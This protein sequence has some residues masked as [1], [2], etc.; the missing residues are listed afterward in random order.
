MKKLLICVAAAFLMLGGCEAKP[1][2]DGNIE[3]GTRVI[4]I[5]SGFS[6]VHAYRGETVTL[7]FTGSGSVTLSVPDYEVEQSGN[8]AVSVTFKAVKT[9][10]YGIAVTTDNGTETGTLIIEELADTNVYK[11]V[12]AQAFEEAMTGQFLLLDVRTK[13]EYE[14]G[15]IDGAVLI[16]H[17]ELADRLDEIKGYDKVLVYCASGNRSVAASQI[18]INAGFEEVYNLAYGYADWQD[19]KQG[20]N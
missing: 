5:G 2:A 16:P 11:S 12:D 15:H 18:L 14:S 6:D 13:Y 1:S 8:D 3:N 9:G 20:V 17:N 4:K 10:S 19:Y 7:D